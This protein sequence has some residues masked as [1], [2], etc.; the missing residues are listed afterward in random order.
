M[1]ILLLRVAANG[2]CQAMDMENFEI[3]GETGTAKEGCKRHV[4]SKSTYK[5]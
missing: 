5:T 4:G 1:K 3:G 2:T